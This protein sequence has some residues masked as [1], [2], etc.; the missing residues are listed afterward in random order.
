MKTTDTEEA[1][2]VAQMHARDTAQ[3]QLRQALGAYAT[4]VAVIT[5][6][7]EAGEPVGI[8]VN[9]FAS[10]SLAPPLILWSLNAQ[11]PS[12]S[13]FDRAQRFAVNVL[14]EEQAALSH[15]FASR[16]PRKFSD[17]AMR[18]GVEGIPLLQNCAALF[19]CRLQM[20]HPGGDHVIYIGAVEAFEA[21]PQRAPLIFHE[22][23]YRRIG[24]A[25]DLD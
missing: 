2:A 8:T 5:T 6:L 9:S 25:L 7:T 21:D 15:R 1:E 20:Q 24:P 11:S 18:Q 4:G 12:R 16:T 22:G 13:H 3:R 17:V 23:R 19:E 14:S 10:L